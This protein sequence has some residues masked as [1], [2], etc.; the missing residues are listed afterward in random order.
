MSQGTL[1]GIDQLVL[2][3]TAACD[4]LDL[5]GQVAI[6][7]GTS[8]T[9]NLLNRIKAAGIVGLIA[10]RPDYASHHVTVSRP[11]LEV[12]SSRISEMQRRSGITD[13]LTSATMELARVT[14]AD[15]FAG[16]VKGVLPD[17][18]P[19][20]IVVDRIL[21][22]TELLRFAPLPAPRPES[23]SAIDR[24]IDGAIDMAVLMCWHI[25]RESED[26]DFIHAATLGALLHDCGLVLI[27]RIILES[28][29]PL[30]PAL[31]REIKRHPYLG[32]RG[33]SPLGDAIS[34]VARDIILLHHENN[35]GSGYPLKRSGNGIPSVARLAHI[36]DAYIALVSPRPHRKAVTP[37]RAIEI[38]MRD[39]G[40]SFHK[41]TLRRFIERTG[42]YPLGSA[43]VLSSNE[44]GVVVGTGDKGPFK[45]IVDVY[46][47]RFHQFSQTP[48]RIDLGR[49]GF[50]YIRQVMK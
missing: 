25:R 5:N 13:S 3:A 38:L 28:D 27:R 24:L 39:S 33:L 49:D 19:L 42:R 10:G 30:S 40:R 2:G 9:P 31:L 44:I 48:Q 6:P 8:I 43:V 26:Q 16:F 1:I 34:E 18:N 20:R 17:I 29:A 12:I 36:L 32:M 47:S 50:K 21:H 35:D 14:L 45:P 41:G 11:T 7:T 23:D 22:D 37:H 15:S 4:L 46:F